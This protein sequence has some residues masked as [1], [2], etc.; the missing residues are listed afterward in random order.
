[1]VVEVEIGGGC[2]IDVVGGVGPAQLGDGGLHGLQPIVGDAR[3][4]KSRGADLEHAAHLEQCQ[5]DLTLGAI[6]AGEGH[7]A[8]EILPGL[9]LVDVGARALA[10]G[11]DAA[12]DQDPGGLTGGQARDGQIGGEGGLTGQGRTGRIGAADNTTQQL[13]DGG[14]DAAPAHFPLLLTPLRTC[15]SVRGG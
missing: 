5:A 14:V 4:G 15:R 3:G 13:L 12:G 2:G 9:G 6:A 11:Q 7:E 1:M 10:R 8:A